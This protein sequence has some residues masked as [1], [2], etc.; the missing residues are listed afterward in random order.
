[1]TQG[2]DADA[3][4]YTL[5]QL[6]EAVAEALLPNERV[7]GLLLFDQLE[8]SLELTPL[9]KSFEKNLSTVTP[10]RYGLSQ[11]LLTLEVASVVVR[12]MNLAETSVATLL[13]FPAYNSGSITKQEIATI[14]PR[15][16]EVLLGQ[17]F[18]THQL[19]KEKGVAKPEEVRELLVSS[20]GDVRVLLLMIATRLFLLRNGKEL[21]TSTEAK[22]IAREVSAFF[23]PITHKLGLYAIKGELED[24]SLKFDNPIAFSDIKKKLGEK[25][26][27]RES[28]MR[29]VVRLL[30]DRFSQAHIRW[31]YHIKSRTKSIYS[32]YNKM[33][34][35]GTAFDDIFDLAALRI[36]ID[37]PQNEEQEAC[38]YF[39][40]LVTD[41]FEPNPNRLRD[42][43]SVP[44]K[45]GYQSLQITVKGP[46]EKFVEVQI[47]T[48][49]MDEIAE[50]GVA[51]HWR[52]KGLGGE[53]NIDG[54]LLHA[55]ELLEDND[56]DSAQREND[57]KYA[58]SNVGCCYVFTP[59]GKL[60]KL[61]QK[62]TVLDFAF[63]IHSNVGSHAKSGKINGQNVALRTE[64][65]N[66]DTVQIITDRNQ[67]P[68]KDWLN[69]VT[70]T[71]AKNK[72]KRYL[73]EEKEGTFAEIR[74]QIERR[75]RNRK[76]PYNERAIIQ[77]FNRLGYRNYISFY[78][79]IA[80]GK[81]DVARF[82]ELYEAEVTTPQLDPQHTSLKE[83]AKTTRAEETPD[84]KD[85]S[86]I[87]GE[88]FKNIYY[89]LAKCCSPQ[90]GDAIFAY[91]SRFGIRIHRYDC[92]NAKDIFEN[93]RSRVLPAYWANLEGESQSNLYVEALDEPETTGR[94]VSLCKNSFG[95][96][97]LSYNIK[98]SVTKVEAEF[99]LEGDQQA[100]NAL[101]N[102][103]LATK[104]VI[105]VSR[106]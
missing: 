59:M 88:N 61:P 99:T 18:S 29:R 56:L 37:A 42:W 16:T 12:E 62:A 32:I 98:A 97:L 49:R 28:Y 72:I 13:L 68:S 87:V 19:F 79:A 73:R 44:K 24:L 80:E 50:H 94:I 10:G 91:P 89:E 57:S 21:L 5:P 60:I 58:I 67:V 69:I 100:I 51:A 23:T 96:K 11:L 40:S 103:L 25:K 90:Y 76:I 2:G 30:E 82:L 48:T 64:L 31:D 27:Q 53:A 83:K 63:A 41:L 77:T 74:E 20:A 84:V 6:R 45:N 85:R 22:A 104:G 81:C 39:Y 9:V 35:K 78:T 47:R 65:K 4:M 75:L 43:V 26:E 17:L 46:E 102:K 1:M 8:E 34:K 95:V 33:T 55:R 105:S 38:W 7:R 86:V 3:S 54:S 52:Y 70:S 106:A 101:R 15:G 92:P 93:N 36:I 14:S 66:G 71:S